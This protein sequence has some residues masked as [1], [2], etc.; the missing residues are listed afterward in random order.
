MKIYYPILNCYSRRGGRPPRLCFRTV[1]A[2][3]EAHRSSI[4]W[5]LSTALRVKLGKYALRAC[6]LPGST[7]ACH[8]YIGCYPVL[9]TYG[10]LLTSL[11]SN[12]PSPRQH[13]PGI[14]QGVG[15]SGNPT[16]PGIRLALTQAS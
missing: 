14:T 15:F 6:R 10:L 12:L 11:P 4:G 16:P 8:L 3:F 7:G 2:P 9:I 5:L 13:I 1:R